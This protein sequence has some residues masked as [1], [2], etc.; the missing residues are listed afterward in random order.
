MGFECPPQQTTPDFL[1]S[2]TS[3]SERTPRPG[4]EDRVPR[5]PKEFAAKWRNSAEYKQLQFEIKS[6]GEKYPF[7]GK[8]YQ[9][10]LASRKWEKSKHR[11]VILSN[12]ADGQFNSITVYPLIL[13]ADKVMSEEG[14]LEVESRTYIYVDPDLWEFDHVISGWFCVLQSAYVYRPRLS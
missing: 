1:T 5:S 3:T 14:I 9:D 4:Y 2:L 13:W 8:Q 12:R 6:F 11:F 7:K 10:F